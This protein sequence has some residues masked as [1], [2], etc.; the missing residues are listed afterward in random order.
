[1]RLTALSAAMALTAG[2]FAGTAVM[3]DEH[4]E[5]NGEGVVIDLI[6]KPGRTN[7]IL[8]KAHLLAESSQIANLAI[9]ACVHA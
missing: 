9:I 3:A 2:A 8:A 1:M 5:L 7:G 4:E 6:V